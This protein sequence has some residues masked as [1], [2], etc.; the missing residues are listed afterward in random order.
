MADIEGPDSVIAHNSQTGTS[1]VLT[2]EPVEDENLAGYNLY[3]S[4]SLHST[5]SKLN[6]NPL[7]DNQYIDEGLNEDQA[8]YYWICSEGLVGAESDYT[9][10]TVC[11]PSVHQAAYILESEDGNKKY[12]FDASICC[13]ENKLTEDAFIYG[14][15]IIL[16][17]VINDK[18]DMSELQVELDK[19]VR[20]VGRAE[21]K[22]TVDPG[23]YYRMPKGEIKIINDPVLISSGFIITMSS[24]DPYA[25]NYVECVLTDTFDSVPRTFNIN[26]YGNVPADLKITLQNQGAGKIVD[27]E[28]QITGNSPSVFKGVLG[29]GDE[30]IIDSSECRVLVNEDN[31]LMNFEGEFLICPPDSTVELVYMHDPGSTADSIFIKIQFRDRWL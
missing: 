15:E 2:W 14:R 29:T 30:L 10:P 4:Q 6:P 31:R 25:Y 28:F 22:L 19:I 20:V 13:L 26:N 24:R 23:R 12:V 3:R 11:S 5:L 21:L 17:G 7:I 8:Y 1:I 27:P 9:G 16:N 18:Q